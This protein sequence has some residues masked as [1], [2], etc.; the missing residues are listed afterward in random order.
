MPLD[1]GSQLAISVSNKS[2]VSPSLEKMPMKE[3]ERKMSK[4]IPD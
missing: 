3:I 2:S 1:L 4:V